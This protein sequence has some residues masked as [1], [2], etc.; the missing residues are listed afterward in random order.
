M[1]F[2]LFFFVLGFRSSVYC[3]HSERPDSVSRPIDQC[4][5]PL[6]PWV[7][8]E[9]EVLVPGL[10]EGFLHHFGTHRPAGPH[11]SVL[12]SQNNDCRW[13]DAENV[14]S[15]HAWAEGCRHGLVLVRGGNR[16]DMERWQDCDTL[17]HCHT[18]LVGEAE[19]IYI[20]L[21]WSCWLTSKTAALTVFQSASLNECTWNIFL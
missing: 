16:R 9:C 8:F 1:N 15:D 18:G 17:Y 5:L 4:P 3:D 11:C 10:H 21:V 14:H 13:P 6:Q 12:E 2:G 7:H 20:C 19:L